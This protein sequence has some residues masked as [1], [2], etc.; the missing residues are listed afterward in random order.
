[1]SEQDTEIVQFSQFSPCEYEHELRADSLDRV[2]QNGM[3]V[4]QG[5]QR[6]LA[7]SL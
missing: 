5:V 4:R 7:L 2:P 1:M 3:R 6:T